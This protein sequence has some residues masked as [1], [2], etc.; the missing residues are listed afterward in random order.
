M[1]ATLVDSTCEA[2]SPDEAPEVPSAAVSDLCF[3]TCL[4]LA[5]LSA[6]FCRVDLVCRFGGVAGALRLAPPTTVLSVSVRV[7]LPPS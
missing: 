2:K 3:C 6:E 5:F 1:L 4:L 7:G